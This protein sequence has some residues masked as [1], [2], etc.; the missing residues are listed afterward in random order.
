MIQLEERSSAR[1]ATSNKEAA[2]YYYAAAKRLVRTGQGLGPS[3]MRPAGPC[4]D[5]GFC[6]VLPLIVPVCSGRLP[7]SGREAKEKLS[8]LREEKAKLEKRVGALRTKVGPVKAGLL[9]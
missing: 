8:A 6:E 2:G 3:N 1:S 4:P 5:S 9:T 7:D